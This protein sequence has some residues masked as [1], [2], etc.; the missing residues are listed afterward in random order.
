MSENK[1]D[2]VYIK[3]K[4]I[5]LHPL[6]E[7]QSELLASLE[8]SLNSINELS[9]EAF[10][11][12]LTLHPIFVILDK[13]NEYRVVCGIRSF[14]IAC[15]IFDATEKILVT[16]VNNQSSEIII[17]AI[18]ADLFLSPLAFSLRR[19]PNALL[20]IYKILPDKIA[21]SFT[22]NLTRNRSKFARSL[23]VSTNTLFYR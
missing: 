6:I 20:D 18:Y 22:P 19:P 4:D 2:S 9:R 1:S 16:P 10:R 3:L 15:R 13:Q 7:S 14:N 23:G 11:W 5:K 8:Y 21:K 17:T 12:I